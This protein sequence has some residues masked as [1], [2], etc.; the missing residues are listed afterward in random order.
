MDLTRAAI[1]PCVLKVTAKDARATS[2]LARAPPRGMSTLAPVRLSVKSIRRVAPAV[3]SRKWSLQPTC[4]AASATAGSKGD[5]YDG[6]SQVVTVLGSQWG[7]EG[8]GKLVD[9]IAQRYDVVARCQVTKC[10]RSSL[11][12]LSMCAFCARSLGRKVNGR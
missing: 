2:S 1:A 10:R 3:N 12:D 11:P 7:D 5:K 4:A 8:K 6:L 9:I